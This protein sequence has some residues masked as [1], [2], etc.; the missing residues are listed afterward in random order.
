[1]KTGIVP[2]LIL[3][4]QQLKYDAHLITSHCQTQQPLKHACYTE[5]FHNYTTNL[6]SGWKLNQR[7]REQKEG[8]T[9]DRSGE[10]E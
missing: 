5:I 6:W 1:M 7:A 2:G 3:G 9:G 10:E 8:K 4:Y